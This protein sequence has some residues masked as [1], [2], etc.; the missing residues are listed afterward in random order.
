MIDN[1]ER[2]DIEGAN[3]IGAAEQASGISAEN[4]S[5]V[6]SIVGAALARP[7]LTAIFAVLITVVGVWSFFRL[8]VDAY[9]D[10]SPPQVEIISQWPGH[11][12]EEV[13]RLITV[14]TEAGMNGTPNLKVMRSVSLY[15]LSDVV[16]TFED[17]TDNYFARQQ[18]FERLPDLELPEGVAPGVVP[19]SSPSGLV[20]RYVLQSPDRSAMELKNIQDWV[21]EK[22]YKSVPGVADMSSLGGTTMQY[23]VLLDPNKLAGAGLT[24][25]AVG[26][27]LG[28]NNANA[29][30]GF[31]SEGGQ[32]FYVR[33]LGRLNTTEDIGNVVV[34]VKNGTPVLVKDV[35]EVVIGNAPRLGQFG[36]N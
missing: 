24:V 6:D 36:C 11:A 5:F 10:L 29:G 23:Q 18:V 1:P 22:Q 14:P 9:P 27:A 19:L 20:Y 33:G 35:G 25:S 2:S 16:L 26:S 8:P 17:K 12:A 34:A 21:L 31:Y 30:G 7:L 13:E 28:A 4:P 3:E 15:G 32:F